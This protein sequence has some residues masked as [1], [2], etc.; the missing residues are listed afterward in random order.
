MLW[1]HLTATLA[2]TLFGLDVPSYFAW[3]SCLPCSNWCNMIIILSFR[4]LGPAALRSKFRKHWIRNP[5]SLS[6]MPRLQQRS[7]NKLCRTSGLRFV[8]RHVGDSAVPTTK[9]TN[10]NHVRVKTCELYLQ[11]YK[12]PSQSL[13]AHTCTQY[14]RLVSHNCLLVVVE[15]GSWA[16][17]VFSLWVGH[18]ATPLPPRM[19]WN[20]M[21]YRGSRS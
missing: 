19:L 17:R 10:L 11:Q 13:N 16:S 18:A 20:T 5:E 4:Y 2:F 9:C 8:G 3:L 1:T 6:A 7:S 14:M 12:D 21:T 15:P